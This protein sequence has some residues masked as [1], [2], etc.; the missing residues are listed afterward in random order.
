[1]SFGFKGLKAILCLIKHRAMKT[2]GKMEINLH[3]FLMWTLNE[4]EWPVSSFGLFT[5]EKIPSFH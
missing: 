2:Y 4:S 5:M 3:A 1:M